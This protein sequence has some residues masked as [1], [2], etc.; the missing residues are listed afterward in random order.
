MPSLID[1]DAQSPELDLGSHLYSFLAKLKIRL[2]LTI[3]Y[4]GAPIYPSYSKKKAKFAFAQR[5]LI[6]SSHSRNSQLRI[7]TSNWRV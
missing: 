6:L 3:K 4:L 2:A 7:T 5:S 1:N